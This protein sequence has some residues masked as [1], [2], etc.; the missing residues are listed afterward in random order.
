MPFT[1]PPSWTMPEYTAVVPAMMKDPTTA[2][3]MVMG[4]PMPLARAI[5]GEWWSRYMYVVIVRVEDTSTFRRRS[6]ESVESR[7]QSSQSS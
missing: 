1:M 5:T 6:E 7:S 2:P 4:H 3:A